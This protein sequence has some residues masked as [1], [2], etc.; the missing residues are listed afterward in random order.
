LVHYSYLLGMTSRFN[1]DLVG[2]SPWLVSAAAIFGWRVSQLD[3][4]AALVMRR[5]MRCGRIFGSAWDTGW[6]TW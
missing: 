2:A 6:T 4:F 3:H 1:E 5:E